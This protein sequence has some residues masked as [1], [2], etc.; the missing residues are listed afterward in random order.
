MWLNLCS[1]FKAT[2]RNK[3]LASR[4][5]RLLTCTCGPWYPSIC[6]VPA[7]NCSSQERAGTKGKGEQVNPGVSCNFSPPRPDFL[8]PI[9]LRP[10]VCFLEHPS[11][12]GLGSYLSQGQTQAWRFCGTGRE[13]QLGPG[14]SHRTL[15]TWTEEFGFV[16]LALWESH[17]IM[18]EGVRD[19]IQFLSAPTVFPHPAIPDGSSS[20]A[21]RACSVISCSATLWTVATRLL[22]PWDSPGKNTGEGCHCLLQGI[23]LTQ[24]SN[25]HFPCLLHWQADSLPVSHLG[26]PQWST[27][28]HSNSLSTIRLILIPGV[29]KK[30]E[31]F[32]FIIKELGYLCICCYLSLECFSLSGPSPAQ[33]L[34]IVKVLSGWIASQKNFQTLLRQ[35]FCCCC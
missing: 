31:S 13:T 7:L 1:P 30:K 4:Q 11:W 14:G 33:L 25:L 15:S 8:L 24:G 20:V 35:P 29:I 12:L 10:Q 3:W 16:G 17:R 26:K 21:W 6:A 28:V 19:S 2:A 32:H 27:I 9:T 23:F 22:C 34:L 5:L 18:Q